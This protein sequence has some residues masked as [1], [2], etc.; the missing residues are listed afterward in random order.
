M[1][2]LIL[3]SLILG[4]TTPTIEVGWF[5]VALPQNRPANLSHRLPI[6][7]HSRLPNN[8]VARL[9]R[10][11]ISSR[12]DRSLRKSEEVSCHFSLW[13]PHAYTFANRFAEPGTRGIPT[14]F[15]IVASYRIQVFVPAEGRASFRYL[16]AGASESV[17]VTEKGTWV[18]IA[19]ALNQR[20]KPTVVKR[21]RMPGSSLDLNGRH[22]WFWRVPSPT[23]WAASDSKDLYLRLD[24]ISARRAED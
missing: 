16:P 14:T 24:L 15:D 21:D 9:A 5:A 13:V 4:S 3:S 12:T 11:N 22:H 7:T 18:T 8:V 17:D 20:I 23:F 10:E 2:S 6:L 1:T 19:E